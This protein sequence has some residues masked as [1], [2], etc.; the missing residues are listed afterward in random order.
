MSTRQCHYALVVPELI[1]N[2]HPNYRRVM[3]ALVWARKVGII[4]WEWMAD[5]LRL[6]YEVSMWSGLADYAATVRSAYRR[7]VWETQPEYVEVV[8]EK[9]ALA[10]VFVQVVRPYGVTLNV[11][12][13]YESWCAVHD[14][15]ERFAAYADRP[16]SLLY[17]GDLDP[18]GEDMVRDLR[19][20]LEQFDC[21]PE[22]VKVALTREDVERY[23]LPTPPTKVG[24]RRR[25]KFVAEHGDI[26]VE[27]DAL[28]VDLLRDRI[29]TAV[30]AHM[31]LDALAET[32]ALE[33]EERARI[34][35]R[36]GEDAT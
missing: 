17:F 24:D 29:R 34:A 6:P 8:V 19:V 20:R 33:R 23:N 4:P 30:E 12:R 11:A 10:E 27:L 2:T 25:A 14:I 26:A 18:S 22:L 35:A 7:D 13:G 31:D 16:C 9:D 5:R 1:E 21:T 28:P 15:A 3:K 36:L 32:Q